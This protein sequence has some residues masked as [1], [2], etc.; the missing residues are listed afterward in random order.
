MSAVPAVPVAEK[1][2]RAMFEHDIRPGNRPVV[3][4]GLVADWPV[5][6]AARTS[7][8]A[9]GAYLKSFDAGRPA[10]V[11]IC[12]A[13]E[14]GR[15]FYNDDMSGMNYRSIPGTVT[16]V[17]D[18]LLADKGGGDSIYVQAIQ[19]DQHLPG[20]VAALPMPL[21][22]GV[23][24]RLWIGN[25]ILT[26]THFDESVNIACHVAGEKTFT[27]FPPE[28]VANLYP[29]PLDLTPAGVPVSMVDLD[30]PDLERFPNFKTA[31]AAAQAARLEPGDALFI[32][33][34]WWH[35][36]RTTGPLNLLVNYWWNEVPAAAYSPFSTLYLAA[37]S[38]K[39]VPADQRQAWRDLV[40]YFIFD[41]GGE[42]MGHL[43]DVPSVFQ[44][45][46][47]TEQMET[48]KRYFRE[49]IKL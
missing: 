25:S 44:H 22:D 20:M 32:P 15:Y 46:L 16:Q 21:V 38:L 45:D 13:S 43:P 24:P 1:V 4:K 28:Q 35:H 19:A 14:Q 23:R 41:E 27:L 33:A 18:R 12:P 34:L 36:V 8:E 10:K 48:Y 37:L 3:L 2:D 39:R 26:Q 42:P 6:R 9:L 29:G 17:V 30:A 11:A 31:L 47:T 40:N 7:P 49:N 5:V